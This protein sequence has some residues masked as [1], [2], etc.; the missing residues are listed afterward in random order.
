[1][2][3]PLMCSFKGNPAQM[4]LLSSCCEYACGYVSHEHVDVCMYAVVVSMHV[5]VFLMSM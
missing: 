1:M 5:V 2:C 3:I 4:W